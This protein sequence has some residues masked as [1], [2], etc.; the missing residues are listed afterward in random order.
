MCNPWFSLDWCHLQYYTVR[1]S[2]DNNHSIG[3]GIQGSDVPLQL[4]RYIP[5]ENDNLV[6]TV[7][8]HEVVPSL[9]NLAGDCSW[10]RQACWCQCT[11]PFSF[12]GIIQYIHSIKQW[13][14]P[15]NALWYHVGCITFCLL[16]KGYPHV[17]MDLCILTTPLVWLAS[18]DPK[19]AGLQR[20]YCALCTML[21]PD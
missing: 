12:A 10:L 19:V 15:T 8:C 18:L 3:I 4:C 7:P 6:T 21:V 11:F 9:Y 16:P 13:W 17:G 1:V 5:Y 20:F 2:C 14:N